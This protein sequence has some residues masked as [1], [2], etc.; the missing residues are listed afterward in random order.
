VGA[1]R[2]LDTIVRN[3]FSGDVLDL[4]AWTSASRTRRTAR[5]ARTPRPEPVGEG[6]SL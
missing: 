6:G 4:Q 3:T 1:V 5:G 2:Q